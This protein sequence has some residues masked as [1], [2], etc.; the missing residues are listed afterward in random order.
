MDKL[1]KTYLDI[2]FSQPPDLTAMR[3]LL[4][5]DFWFSGP[6]LTANSADD[7]IAQLRAMNLGGLQAKSMTFAQH[8]DGVAV[9]YEMLTPAGQIPTTE[10]FWIRESRIAGIKLLNDPRPLLAAFSNL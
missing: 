9:L 10:W 7:Y 6:L 5:D 2:F 4:T 1:V 8:E 3:A